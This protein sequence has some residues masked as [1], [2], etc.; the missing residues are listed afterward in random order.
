MK[1]D[2]LRYVVTRHDPFDQSIDAV[3]DQILALIAQAWGRA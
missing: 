3:N 2:F 1:Q